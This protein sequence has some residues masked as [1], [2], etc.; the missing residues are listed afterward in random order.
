VSTSEDPETAEILSE[1]GFSLERFREYQDRFLDS[2]KASD[3]DYTYGNRLRGHFYRGDE[4]VDSPLIV[5]DRLRESTDSRHCYIA[6]WDNRLDL[7]EGTKCPCLVSAFF[8]YFDGKLNLTA[9]FRTH[10]AMDAW[11]ENLY[12]LMALQRFVA[13]RASTQVGPITVISHSISIDPIA[14]E[15]AKRVVDNKKTDEFLDSSTG[16]YG[17][18]MDPNGE[19]AITVDI[20]SLELV[21]EHSYGGM[22]IGEYRGKTSEEI[23]RQLARDVALS[24]I[25]HALY[26]GRELAR[27]QVQLDVLRTKSLS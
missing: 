9:N 25:S 19:F 1:Y 7:P 20:A 15:K 26:L 4:V 27:K 21:V 23:E 5:A 2:Q 24:Q 22:K 11:P 3:L 14:L 8:R 6:L 18:R 10:N 12:G 17:P 16:K 13:D